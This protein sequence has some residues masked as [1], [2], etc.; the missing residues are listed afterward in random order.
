ML[1][2]WLGAFCARVHAEH[3]ALDM[4]G[5]PD[6]S[7]AELRSLLALELPT[8][9]VAADQPEPSDSEHLRVQCTV[10]DATLTRSE[11]GRSRTIALSNVPLP[12]RARVIALAIAELVRPEPAKPSAP[13]PGQVAKV[14]PPTPPPAPATPRTRDRYHL[15]AAVQGSALPLIAL[16]GAL[17][18]RVSIRPLFAW[19][20]A[21]SFSQRRSAIDRGEL[22]VQDMSLRSGPALSFT[23][24]SWTLLL[25]AAAKVS[26]MR[27]S[28]E[29]AD[30]S[31]TRARTF[32]A[33]LLAPTLFAGTSVSLGRGAF[34][35]LELEAGHALRRLRADVQGGGART[36]SAFR[37]S[38]LLGAGFQW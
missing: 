12:L 28:G 34:A 4:S 3:V 2:L 5:C 21:F 16:G 14:A 37:A 15:W 25:G 7:E 31:A 19:S 23:L 27:L 22:R 17:A 18:L 1:W 24:A 32:E 35:A 6:V 33:W 10:S 38:A 30:R 26:Y 8:R 9:L 29:A 36:L 11:L 13:P 20:S